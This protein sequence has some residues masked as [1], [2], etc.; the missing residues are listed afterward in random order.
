M[1]IDYSKGCVNFRDVGEFVNLIAQ[2]E[3][4]PEKRIFRGGKLDYVNS[5][6]EIGNPKTIINLQRG[7]EKVFTGIVNCHFPISNDYEKYNTSDKEVKKWLNKVVMLFENKEISY[8]VFV[9][10]TAGKDRTGVV[11]AALLWVLQIPDDIII[12]EYLLSEGEVN[13]DWIKFSLDG[14]KSNKNYFDR[15]NLSLVRNNILLL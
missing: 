15:V 12:E 4:L 7:A 3:L 10:C 5:L 8:P 14:I 9:H 1:K 2:K 11:I 6:T 13:K